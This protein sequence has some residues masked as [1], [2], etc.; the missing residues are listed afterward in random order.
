MLHHLAA[1]LNLAGRLSQEG[2]GAPLRRRRQ[3]L[4]LAQRL[5]DPLP[6]GL[7][8]PDQS[9]ERFWRA[10]RWGGPGLLLG[11]WLLR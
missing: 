11:L 4:S 3:R 2:S 7:R 5:L 1:V 8:S 10:I 6:Q 9:A